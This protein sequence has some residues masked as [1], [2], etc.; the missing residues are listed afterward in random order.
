MRTVTRPVW[1]RAVL[2]EEGAGPQGAREA[3][4]IAQWGQASPR[5]TARPSEGQSLAG[6]QC[7]EDLAC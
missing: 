1:S 7:G 3:H 4:V 2:T 6:S 5:T